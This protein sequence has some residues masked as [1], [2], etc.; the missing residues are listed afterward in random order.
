MKRRT[1]YSDQFKEKLLAKVFSPNAPNRLELARRAGIP[2]TTFKKEQRTE[3]RQ[4]TTENKQ[5]KQ[6]LHRKE[7]ALVEA[8]ALLLLRKKANLIWGAPEDD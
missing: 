2:Y 5:L 7:K 3:H 8:S 4:L 1:E 6:E